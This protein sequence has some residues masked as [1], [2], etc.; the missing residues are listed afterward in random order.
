[1]SDF[2]SSVKPKLGN[3]ALDLIKINFPATTKKSA[4]TSTPAS[5]PKDS[6]YFK[7]SPVTSAKLIWVI[8][9]WRASISSRS[10]SNGPLNF[11][12]LTSYFIIH[13]LA[14]RAYNYCS[15]SKASTLRIIQKYRRQRHKQL[16]F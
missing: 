10:L 6:M 12:N 5:D 9:S 15:D 3:T 2:S 11:S 13:F 1:M 8:S 4:K 16:V 14:L 7:K